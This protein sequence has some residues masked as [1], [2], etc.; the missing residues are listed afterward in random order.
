MADSDRLRELA[1]LRAIHTQHGPPPAGSPPPPPPPLPSLTPPPPAP[2]AP[3]APAPAAPAAGPVL[4]VSGETTLADLR[5]E[6]EQQRLE[7]ARER[8]EVERLR[9]EL[10]GVQAPGGRRPVSDRGPARPVS[11]RSRPVSDRNRSPRRGKPGES[12]G[13]SVQRR[14][15]PV[16]LI[17]GG[18]LG[19]AL[20]FGGAVWVALGRGESGGDQVA[21]GG[22]TV[23]VQ[24]GGQPPAVKPPSVKPPSG[25]QGHSSAAAA[26]QEK[27]DDLLAGLERLPSD[28]GARRQT[29]ERLAAG[30]RSLRRSAGAEALEAAL[31]RAESRIEGELERLPRQ[32][33]T[34]QPVAPPKPV[35]PRPRPVEPAP[36]EPEPAPRPRP[37]PPPPA[38]PDLGPGTEA[39]PTPPRREPSPALIELFHEALGHYDERDAIRLGRAI[40][41]LERVD[42]DA[43]ETR[44][45][46]GLF[47]DLSGRFQDAVRELEAVGEVGG[48][49]TARALVRSLFATLRFEAARALLPRLDE[50]EAGLWRKLI[51]GPFR[52][53]YPLAAD[54]CEAVSPGGH[55]RVVSDLGLDPTHLA[56]LEKK[57]QGLSEGE[58]QKQVE[59]ARKAH[60]GLTELCDV[61]E[62]AYKAY[63]KLLQSDEAPQVH[64][65]VYVLETRADFDRFSGDLAGDVENVLGYYLPSYRVLVF[66]NQPEGKVPGRQLSQGTL[67]VLLHETFHQWLHLYVEDRPRWFDEGMAEYFGIGEMTGSGLRYGLVPQLHPSRLDNIREALTGVL[68]EP[69][70]LSDMIRAPRSTFYG[71]NSAVNYAQAW[72]FVHYLGSSSKGQ[73]LLREYFHALRR[74]LDQEAAFREVFAGIDFPAL[75]RD[76][77]EYVGRLR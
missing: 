11:D 5:R 3:A 69:M 45:A 14:G 34:P 68:P 15:P 23:T 63:G 73:K 32:P 54:S 49:R 50:R 53:A 19:A 41:S 28:P 57:L 17:A 67:N 66:Y 37:T 52:S 18:L 51:D 12:Q 16:G 55:Y 7:L 74:G 31:D 39:V 25:T 42:P 75:E 36:T 48:L 20:A 46:R 38:K 59:R 6:L 4:P 10:A 9:L 65:T 44:A 33:V 21:Q 76:W 26:D 58:R 72:S 30:V 61:M 43:P 47:M 62:K 2:P 8:L 1:R 29:L 13:G 77:R 35:A 40:T 71:S 64:P 22:G 27:L 60:K 24:P 56:R 70:S